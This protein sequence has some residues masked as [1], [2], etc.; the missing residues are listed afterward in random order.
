MKH[1]THVQ[2]GKIFLLKSEILFI[3]TVLADLCIYT[4]L[5]SPARLT[6]IRCGLV[7]MGDETEK[8]GT[9]SLWVGEGVMSGELSVSPG[10]FWLLSDQ[11]PRTR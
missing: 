1:V 6:A 10:W 8:S 4:D 2:W 7:C 5:N 11:V 3:L 9:E